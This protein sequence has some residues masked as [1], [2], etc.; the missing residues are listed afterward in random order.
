[1]K[2]ERADD[3]RLRLPDAGRRSR[4]VLLLD[5]MNRERTSLMTNQRQINTRNTYLARCEIAVSEQ[6]EE[7]EAERDPVGLQIC[8]RTCLVIEP[9][10]LQDDSRPVTTPGD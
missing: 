1:M 2:Q 4:P 5:T 3:S 7:A 6:L 9:Q 8:S 10:V